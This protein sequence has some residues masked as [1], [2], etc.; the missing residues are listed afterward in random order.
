[1]EFQ[2]FDLK[3]IKTLNYEEQ[4]SYISK[5][6]IPLTNGS[7]CRLLNGK[8]DIIDKTILND[9]YLNRCDKKMQTHSSSNN[10]NK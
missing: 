1:M 2:N 5:Y 10:N 4:K 3:K 6:F 7:H 8:Y 9:T